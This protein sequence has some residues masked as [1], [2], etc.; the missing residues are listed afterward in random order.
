M[1]TTERN[2]PD[3][4]AQP[5]VVTGGGRGLG[6]HIALADTPRESAA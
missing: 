1:S 2:A 6:A 5:V 4:D 3:L